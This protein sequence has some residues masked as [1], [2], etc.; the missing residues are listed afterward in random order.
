MLIAEDMLAAIKSG[1][2]DLDGKLPSVRA[3]MK[4]LG[5]SNETVCRAYGCYII[6]SVKVM[7]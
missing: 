3:L 4:R 5:V 6:I 2:Y 7:F 1:K